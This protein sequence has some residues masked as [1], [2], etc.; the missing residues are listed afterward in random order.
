MSKIFIIED[1]ITISTS[2]SNQFMMLLREEPV[3]IIGDMPAESILV[4]LRS[5]LPRIIILEPDINLLDSYRLISNIKS[6]RDL[7]RSVLFAYT[8]QADTR[9]HEQALN[10]GANHVYH[11]KTLSVED[12]SAKVYTIMNNVYKYEKQI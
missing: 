5:M 2:L 9:R 1:D 6:S 4:R 10:A 11:K 7:D 12:F 3:V 8:R